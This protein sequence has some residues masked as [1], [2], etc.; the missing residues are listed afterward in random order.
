MS[1]SEYMRPRKSNQVLIF[2]NYQLNRKKLILEGIPHLS[3]PLKLKEKYNDEILKY[4]GGWG[5]W[6]GGGFSKDVH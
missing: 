6:G 3:Y 2:P 1:E 4:A 5:G